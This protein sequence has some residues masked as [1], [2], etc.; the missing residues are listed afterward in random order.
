MSYTTHSYVRLFF[1]FTT[2]GPTGKDFICSVEHSF[3]EGFRAGGVGAFLFGEFCSV[4]ALSTF[5]ALSTS[6]LQLGC[7]CTLVVFWFE[8]PWTAGLWDLLLL[9]ALMGDT[10]V[11]GRERLTSAPEDMLTT[12][13]LTGLESGDHGCPCIVDKS[14]TLQQGQFFWCCGLLCLLVEALDSLGGA[15]GMYCGTFM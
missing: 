15:T 6:H 3:V 8:S 1:I 9:L 7:E 14:L 4:W 5:F 13:G 12:S 2:A 11:M 10:G